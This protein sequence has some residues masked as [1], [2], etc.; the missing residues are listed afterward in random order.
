[1]KKE[2][3]EDEQDVEE[4]GEEQD[5][6]KDEDKGWNMNKNE[7][8]HKDKDKVKAVFEDRN[9]SPCRGQSV[10]ALAKVWCAPTKHLGHLRIWIE[11]CPM[12]KHL[13][14]TLL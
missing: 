4:E 14:G 8:G 6:C 5:E 3:E 9:V 13:W 11:S 7:D 2:G 1:M 10:N 12:S